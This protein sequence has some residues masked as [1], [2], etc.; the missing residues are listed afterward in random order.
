MHTA[1][2][3][4][5]GWHLRRI[6]MAGGHEH[7]CGG[8]EI[9]ISRAQ[10]CLGIGTH[11]FTE[12]PG[13]GF[14]SLWRYVLALRNFIRQLRSHD[15]IWLQYGS[16]F[17]LAYLV[18][19]KLF[20]KTVVVTPHLGSGWRSM[21]NGGVRMLCNRL[22]LLADVVFTLYESQPEALRFPPAL[23]RRCRVMGTFLPRALLDG[24][25]P[26][27][28]PSH[29]LRLVHV[30]RL[31]ADKGSFAFLDVCEALQRRGVAFEATLIGPAGRETRQALE[32]SIARRRL[33]VSILGALPQAD[34]IAALRRYDVLVN[35]S[36][37]DAYPL[38]VIEALLCGVVPVCSA[39]PGTIELAAEAPVI[40]L[41]QG[42]D[43]EAAAARIAAIDWTAIPNGADAM[44]SKFSWTSLSRRY[45]SAFAELAA[46]R[47]QAPFDKSLKVVTP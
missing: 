38:T 26:S 20:G 16:V 18:V 35:L 15:I 5:D 7:I 31:S 32:E 47:R 13:A 9:F 22:L 36:L 37:Q 3:Q 39:L 28:I 19:A 44:R 23:T 29:P 27:R 11:Q 2:H 4:D 45:R 6:L 34:L 10:A 17:D 41:V 14:D 8:L 30:A 43:G 12:T 1:Q 33:T 25:L 24:E 21:R 42:Q 40:A 46:G